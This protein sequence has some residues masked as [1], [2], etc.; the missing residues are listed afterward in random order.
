MDPEWREIEPASCVADVL[1]SCTRVVVTV[2]DEQHRMVMAESVPLSTLEF[3]AELRMLRAIDTTQPNTVL[4]V[5]HDGVYVPR[6]SLSRI[7]T[8]RLAQQ[9]ALQAP[10]PRWKRMT[11]ASY[12]AAAMMAIVQRREQLR[13]VEA[14][15]KSLMD[16]VHIRIT[17]Q[18][19]LLAKLFTREEAR[20]RVIHLT[21][22]L[23]AQAVELAA[24][25]EPVTEA[26]KLLVA[27]AK[28][29]CAAERALLASVEA[30]EK[31]R[32]LLA[33]VVAELEKV[34]RAT[35][36][37]KWRLIDGLRVPY[38]IR[39]VPGAAAAA[40]LPG[41]PPQSSESDTDHDSAAN[42]SDIS[43]PSSPSLTASVP[44]TT[45][46]RSRATMMIN[47]LPLN[48]SSDFTG[49]DEEEVATALGYCCHLLQLSAQYLD[50]SF[51]L[52][53][54]SLSPSPLFRRLCLGRFL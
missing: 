25:Q 4:F 22:E 21:Q 47:G 32:P 1:H 28:A 13:K 23:E 9:L 39:P 15:A 49:C 2:W 18:E 44:P 26:Q 35:E 7:G 6:S 27:R 12:D 40:Q 10:E 46:G 38:P 53:S 45:G 34:D 30:F 24:Q 33:T 42:I 5:L 48:D 50:V 8:A 14:E 16:A 37:I 51:F 31:S 54:S 11:V 3:V 20:V 36:Q 29:L 41:P 19:Q 52:S 17:A 43:R